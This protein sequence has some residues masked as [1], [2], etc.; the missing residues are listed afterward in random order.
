MLTK[1]QIENYADVMMWGLTTARTGKFKKGDIIVVTFDSLATK[2]AEAIHIRIMDTGMHPVMKHLSSEIVEYNFYN[3]ANNK[4]L[5]FVAP[6]LEKYAEA[7]NGSIYLNAPQSLTHLKDI[8]PKKIGK[9]AVASRPIRDIMDVRDE[10]GLFGWTLCVFPTEE[11]AKQAGLTLKQYENQIIKACYLNEPD[12]VAKW[13]ALFRE[14]KTVKRWLNK[15]I[16]DVKYYWVESPNMDIHITP[17]EKRQWIGVSGHNIPSFE[18]FISP[19]WRGTEGTYYANQPSFRS[20]NYVEKVTLHFKKGRVKSMSADK[21][22]DYLYSTLNMD[23]GACQIGEFSL[24]DKR[25]SKINKF[26]ASTLFDEN[27]GGKQ[28]NCHI[29]VG[30]SYSDTYSGDPSELTKELKKELGFNYSALHWD[31]VNTEKKLVTAHL[32]NGKTK[33]IY[34]NGMFA[35]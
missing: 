8:D 24:T 12:P 2:L 30:N 28:G 35:Y 26:M 14:A 18:L 9:S 34:E 25:F 27:F 11:L 17:G 31:L 32:K 16:D 5:V 7:L 13:N 19:D 33:V 20:G 21:G 3:K 15:T 6:W 29:A 4:Q 1:K 23:K 10:K 22:E